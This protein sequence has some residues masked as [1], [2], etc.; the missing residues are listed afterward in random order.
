MAAPFLSQTAAQ[1]FYGEQRQS[2]FRPQLVAVAGEDGKVDP[3]RKRLLEA[4]VAGPETQRA[5]KLIALNQYLLATDP[6]RGSFWGC[7]QCDGEL[8]RPTQCGCCG[9]PDCAV[10]CGCRCPSEFADCPGCGDRVAYCSCDGEDGG[11]E[12]S[13]PAGGPYGARPGIDINEERERAKQAFAEGNHARAGASARRA[14]R[15]SEAV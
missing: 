15:A 12:S 13:D 4:L 9:R 10:R 3:P 2:G 11:H 7:S 6:W 14:A 8:D 5:T 1:R